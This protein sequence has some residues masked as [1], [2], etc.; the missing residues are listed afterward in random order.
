[1]ITA[2]VYIGVGVHDYIFVIVVVA[3]ARC[4]RIPYPRLV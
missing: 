2:V 3:Y 4:Y 1:M